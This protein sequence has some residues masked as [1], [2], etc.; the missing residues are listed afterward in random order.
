MITKESG[1]SVELDIGCGTVVFNKK[2]ID[3]IYR[4]TPEE[5][6]RIQE[7]MEMSK[8]L[9]KAKEKEFSAAREK[10]LHDY[11]EWVQ[12]G[13][14]KKREAAHAVN[15][16]PLLKVEN[17]NHIMVEALINGRANA[18]LIVDTGAYDIVLTRKIGERL[19]I[20]LSDNKNE[21]TEVHLTGRRRLAKSV[22]LKSVRIKDVEEKDLMAKVLLEDEDVLGL[23]DGLLGL[24]FLSRFDCMIDLNNMKMR[25]RKK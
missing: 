12:E 10:R 23:K 16:V 19:G 21:M 20:N 18:T 17:S 14:A 8:E 6:L 7:E 25:L 2:Q 22:L 1:D 11:E 15:E 13:L 4:S 9:L 24:V 3:K 5:S